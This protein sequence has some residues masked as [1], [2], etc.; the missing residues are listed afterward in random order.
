[1][2]SRRNKLDAVIRHQQHR[3]EEIREEFHKK[4][5]E[6]KSEET[7]MDRLNGELEDILRDLT[8]KQKECISTNQW[9][10][11]YEFIKRQCENIRSQRGSVQRLTE[12]CEEKRGHLVQTARE[13]KL[14]EQVNEKRKKALWKEEVKQE[15]LALDETA[16]SRYRR[17]PS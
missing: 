9:D 4:K 8:E 14:L 5:N 7:I 16:S 12:H 3:E 2:T 15:Q 11:Y 1:M 17:K 10:L 6:L 13:R